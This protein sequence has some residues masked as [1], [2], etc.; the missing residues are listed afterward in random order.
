M[1]RQRKLWRLACVILVVTTAIAI[2][3]AFGGAIAY[4]PSIGPAPMRFEP[5]A[6]PDAAFAWKLLRPLQPTTGSS[7]VTVPVAETVTNTTNGLVFMASPLPSTNDAIAAAST[8]AADPGTSKNLET[9]PGSTAL[10]ASSDGSSSPVTAQILAGFFKPTAGA[11]NLG[12]TNLT[13]AVVFMPADIGFTPPS[14]GPVPE[15]KAIYKS[16]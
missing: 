10:L 1:G 12:G 9:F 13:G 14:P 8:P 7:A 16:Q 2:T 15:S 11:K 5:V 6:D 4:L 3:H